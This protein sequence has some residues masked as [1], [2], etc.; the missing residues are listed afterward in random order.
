MTD[1]PVRLCISSDANEALTALIEII[2][3]G[4]EGGFVDKAQAA[5]WLILRAKP[6]IE[7]LL[8]EIRR[9]HFD[10]VAYLEAV[11]IKKKRATKEGA[12]CA[13]FDAMA[14]RI[15]LPATKRLQK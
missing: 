4:F 5:S 7:R 9:D 3:H 10:E 14:S 11:L 2:N 15:R 1:K 13:E 12:Q 6:Q 8:P